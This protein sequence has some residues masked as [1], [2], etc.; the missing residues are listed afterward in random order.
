LKTLTRSCNR[1]EPTN[2]L[3]LLIKLLRNMRKKPFWKIWKIIRF[4]RL[5]IYMEM[6]RIKALMILRNDQGYPERFIKLKM[7]S[8]FQM[9]KKLLRK[10]L[11]VS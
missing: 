4:A 8:L 6:A 2:G 5:L 11:R 3:K 1:Q 7:S 9:L 10:S